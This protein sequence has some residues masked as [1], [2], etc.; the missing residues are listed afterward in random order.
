MTE[1]SSDRTITSSCSIP[2]H[3]L[4]ESMEALYQKLEKIEQS[5]EIQIQKNI[6]RKE[7]TDKSI[8]KIKDA[9][10]LQ[11]RETR[12]RFERVEKTTNS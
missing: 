1:N 9:L 12:R 2:K 6:E 11:N 5:N 8:K 3:S 7:E 4:E 10:K